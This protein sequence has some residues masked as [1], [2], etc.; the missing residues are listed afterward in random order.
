MP[1]IRARRI[2]EMR[3]RDDL[4]S[5]RVKNDTLTRF[6]KYDL[7][8]VG[9]EVSSSGA[10]F[11]ATL[12]TAGN[13]GDGFLLVADS[14]I[15]PGSTGVARRM[16]VIPFNTTGKAL[17]DGVFLSAS[18]PG[19]L[20]FTNTG[21]RVGWVAYVSKDGW[22]TVHADALNSQAGLP[23]A[24]ALNDHTDVN[25]AGVVDKE[26][27]AWDSGSATWLPFD[28]YDLLDVNRLVLPTSVFAYDAPNN[29]SEATLPSALAPNAGVVGSIRLYVNGVTDLAYVA[30]GTP[31]AG[32][33]GISGTEL[34]VGG[35]ITAGADTYKVIWPS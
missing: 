16:Y 18:T 27:L 33:W 9:R 26:V 5:Y 7:L 22:V 11:H 29:W 17:G 34:R 32:Q 6:I 35:D 28:I 25:T 13:A 10:F 19:A 20:T 12:A 4:N 24:H 21:E 23:G 30:S 8:R 31:A 2:E 15:L 14:D 3:T 1:G